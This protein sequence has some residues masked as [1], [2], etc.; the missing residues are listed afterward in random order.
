MRFKQKAAL[1]LAGVMLAGSIGMMNPVEVKAGGETNTFTLTV[2]ADT[3]ITSAG[4]N[5]I[6]SVGVSN[7]SITSGSKIEV[8][9]DGGATGRN[10]KNTADG[11]KTIG[12]DIKKSSSA[13]F[14]EKL[15]FTAN[16]SQT[17]GAVV[18]DFS[19]AEEGTY[20]D[21]VS[22]TATLVSGSVTYDRTDGTGTLS[23]DS[24]GSATT[25]EYNSTSYDVYNG[26]ISASSGSSWN[27]AMDFV[28]ALNDAKYDGHNDWQLLD[29]QGM[30]TAWYNSYSGVSRGDVDVLWSSVEGSTKVAYILGCNNGVWTVAVKSG[31]LSNYGFVVL[32]GSDAD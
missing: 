24:L 29:S 5:S 12:Y 1:L 7:V 10:L 20:E 13:A 9:I 31:A 11:S 19:S 14:G 4:W 17:I 16:G 26:F 2:P 25:W 27:D 23:S 22:F 21:T 3:N 8:K 15:E 28:A 32:R 6:G 30:A 18:S